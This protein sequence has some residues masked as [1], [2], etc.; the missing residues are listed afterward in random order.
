VQAINKLKLK[1]NKLNSEKV[2]LKNLA[3]NLQSKMDEQRKKSELE[4]IQLQE[5]YK[6]LNIDDVQLKEILENNQT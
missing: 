2:D 1:N 6:K 5:Y 4:H 3:K